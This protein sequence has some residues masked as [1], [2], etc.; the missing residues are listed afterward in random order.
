MRVLVRDGGVVGIE[1]EPRRAEDRGVGVEEQRGV[2]IDVAGR[3]LAVLRGHQDQLGAALGQPV[4]AR[5]L[6]RA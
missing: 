4:L 5:Q 1:L 3:E 2:L 6:R